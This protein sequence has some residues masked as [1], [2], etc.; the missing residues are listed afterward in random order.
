MPSLAAVD[1]AAL[2]G[3]RPFDLVEPTHP[4]RP[5]LERFWQEAASCASLGRLLDRP[6]KPASVRCVLRLEPAA[7]SLRWLEASVQRVVDGALRAVTLSFRPGRDRL[8]V[9]AL[10][11][12]PRLSLDGVEDEVRHVLQY[13]P[14]HRFTYRVGP[15]TIGKVP[16]PEDLHGSWRRLVGVHR[17]VE[18]AQPGFHVAAPLALD[19]ERGVFYQSALPGGSLAEACAGDTFV[20]VLLA[21]GRVHGELHGLRVEGLPTWRPDAML[22]AARE[23]AR[24][25][26]A[27]RPGAA[28]LVAEIRELLVAT[29]PSPA[30]TRFCHGDLTLGH[31]LEHEGRVGVLD[32]DGCRNGDPCQDVA[33]L[34][35]FLR[36]DVPWLR[37]RY[38]QAEAGDLE[39]DAAAGAFLVGHAETGPALDPARLTWYLLAHELHYLARQFKRDLHAPL[40]F[41]RGLVRL[42]VLGEQLRE[43]LGGRRRP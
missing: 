32:F 39:L 4:F 33:R 7:P 19:R 27:F 43:Q 31:L 5:A 10:P 9:H 3:G 38:E 16:R 8:E 21:A 37:L 15:G 12:D 28:R 24:L 22:P 41:A 30:P 26:A 13:V 20:D 29:L 25:V 2:P 11:E 36:L 18:R 42:G 17:A 6:G 34:L 23:H 35:A 14:R 1:V 40:A